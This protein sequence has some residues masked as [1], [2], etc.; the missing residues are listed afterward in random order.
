MTVEMAIRHVSKAAALMNCHAAPLTVKQ[1]VA[2][3]KAIHDLERAVQPLG[4]LGDSSKQI[5]ARFD[6]VV[7]RHLLTLPP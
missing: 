4:N 3:H 2:L 7:K 6:R 5:E 1:D